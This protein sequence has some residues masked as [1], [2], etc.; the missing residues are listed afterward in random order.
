V[1]GL[2]ENRFSHRQNSE[3]NQEIFQMSLTTPN[4]D[5]LLLDLT[6]RAIF[7]L[8]RWLEPCPDGLPAPEFLTPDEAQKVLDILRRH[9]DTR[10]LALSATV[11]GEREVMVAAAAA[12][13]K[14]AETFDYY[15]YLHQKKGT[16][17]G[18]EKMRKN[19]VHAADAWNAYHAIERT[20]ATP[21]AAPD[22][23]WKG[24]A[25]GHALVIAQLERRIAELEA[26]PSDGITEHD[27]YAPGEFEK[28]WSKPA[29]P[30]KKEGG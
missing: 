16:E 21:P 4:G 22:S 10:A 8:E 23:A 20:L 17:D 9:D 14:A 24:I 7:R 19:M 6:R 25:E 3:T 29:V 27:I 2:P 18:Q 1:L 26:A 13:K 12:L 11:G 30:A 15:A 5:E 28:E